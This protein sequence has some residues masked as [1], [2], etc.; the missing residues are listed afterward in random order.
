MEDTDASTETR[1]LS[2]HRVRPRRSNAVIEVFRSLKLHR[3]PSFYVFAALWLFGLASMFIFP[4]PVPITEEALAKYEAKLDEAARYSKQH[5]DSTQAWY[6][7][8]QEL[9]EAKT[10]F[11]RFRAERRPI[12][13]DKKAK[14]RAAYAIVREHDRHLESLISAAK[15]ELGLW[16]ELGVGE[17]RQLFW[18]SFQAGKVFGRRQTIWDTAFNLLASNQADRNLVTAFVQ[19]ICTAMVNFTAGMLSSVF[20]FIFQLPW[21][22]MSYQAS[23]PSMIAFF[24][25]ATLGC[26][27]VIC[28]YLLG[29]Y[30]AG[31]TA[32]YATVSLTG[33]SRRL[34]A[35][36]GSRTYLE[37][38]HAE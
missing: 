2:E 15:A 12:V 8:A 16:S 32:I 34:G 30:L 17:G 31:A 18:K 26:I 6:A 21:L 29:L 11:W 10:W 23:L 3:K 36:Q 19:L 20:I 13:L 37:R 24:A 38:P 25:L 33:Q 35:G 5:A 27:S 7:A 22:L 14:E 28:S 9:R 1:A 4:A